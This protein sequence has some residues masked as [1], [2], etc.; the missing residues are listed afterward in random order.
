MKALSGDQRQQIEA[1]GDSSPLI[2]EMSGA[3][4]S[5]LYLLEYH[6][7]REV[8]RI[9]RAERWETPADEL[10]LKETTILTALGAAP[11]PTPTPLGTFMRNGVLMSWLPGV[12]DLPMRPGAY[13]LE[14]LARCL[15]D[16]HQC[17]VEVPYAYESWNG[18]T[19]DTRPDWWTDQE[20]WLGAQALAARTPDFDP[21][22]VHRD[23]HPVN[24]LWEDWRISGIVD[25][26]NACMGPA[27]IDVAHCRLNL[28][29]MY[30]Q[31]T[32][33]AFLAAYT[34]A[35]P[36]Y[37]HDF[38]WDLDDALGALPNVRP[39]APWAQFGLT[40]LSTEMVRERLQAFVS[41]AVLR[42]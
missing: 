6:D 15:A 20:L 18:T 28:A 19:I 12:V 21:I 41:A 5:D 35:A 24:V 36:G 1:R 39:Y 10:S 17:G 4:S 31:P 3:T 7:R 11:L 30:G 22:F 14:V 37:E 32:A 34:Q 2:S 26:I 16:I 42:H 27:G 9:F 40:G 29:I 23:F 13:W 25:W 33:D 38:Y 8:L